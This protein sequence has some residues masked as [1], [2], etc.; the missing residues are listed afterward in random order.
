M[1]AIGGIVA[2][3]PARGGSKGFPGKNLALFG[4]RP[5]ITWTIAAA[6]ESRAVARVIVS[7]DDPAIAEA[8][9]VAGAEVPFLRPAEL[10]ADDSPI[11]LVVQHALQWL[12]EHSG[13]EPEF[14][15]LLQPTS[16]LRDSVDIDAAVDLARDRHAD[17]V[18]SVFEPHPHP[19]LSKMVMADGT[20]GE[21]VTGQPAAARRQDLPASAAPNGAIYLIRPA[22]LER[23]GSFCP[24]GT[25]PYWMPRERSVDI[26]SVADMEMAET[27]LAARRRS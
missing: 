6:V 10:A 9:I 4:G 16:P 18:M 15:L 25:W 20:L 5:L 3:V 26:D 19:F 21:L 2:L 8:A 22:V 24:P 14:L 27:L 13:L 7:T 17:A 11:L 12:R 23:S 1:N